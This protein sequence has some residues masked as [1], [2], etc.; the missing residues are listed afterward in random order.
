MIG[1]VDYDVGNLFSLA[2][3]LRRL[4]CDYKFVE[5]AEDSWDCSSLI[6]PGVGAFGDAINQLQNKG[7]AEVVKD[8]THNGKP[9]LGICLGMQLLF[10]SSE[11]HGF[12]QGLGLLKGTII[13]L[14]SGV[15]VP[16][17]GW[18]SLTLEQDHFLFKGLGDPYVYFVHS[19]YAR[20]TKENILASTDYAV[21]VPAVVGADN[22]IGMQFHPEKSSQAGMI[23]LKNWVERYEL[24]T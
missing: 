19:Y 8:W 4:D 10:E 3:A 11:E 15:K 1:I 2:A 7:L 16:H 6:L 9:L 20:T 17:M 18:N 24:V 13:R 5:K 14:P 23:L 22:I 21:K 12:H